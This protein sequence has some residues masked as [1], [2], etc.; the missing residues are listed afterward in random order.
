V[1]QPI[2]E[3]ELPIATAGQRVLAYSIDY[4]VIVAIEIALFRWL[5]AWATGLDQLRAWK[6]PS[7]DDPADLQRAAAALQQALAPALAMF[8]LAQLIIEIAYFIA[9]EQVSGGRSV[10]KWLIGLR[11]VSDGGAVLS[12]RASVVRSLLRLVDELPAS[13]LLGFVVM[14]ASKRHQRLGD[15]AAGTVVRKE[16][17]GAPLAS[18]PAAPM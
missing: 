18:R 7:L 11:V 4:L 15:L 6:P 3:P 2:A 1:N 10:G 17:R 13:Y 14:L 5:P 12:A 9:A 16:P 8:L